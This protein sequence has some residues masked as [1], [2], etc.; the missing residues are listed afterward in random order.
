MFSLRW[1]HSQD[2]KTKNEFNFYEY[3][4]IFLF[5]KIRKNGICFS[6]LRT[7]YFTKNCAQSSPVSKKCYS[8]K[9]KH[10]SQNEKK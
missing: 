3:V 10:Y 4:R 6:F 7:F 9:T 5:V 8:Q 1:N 2:A